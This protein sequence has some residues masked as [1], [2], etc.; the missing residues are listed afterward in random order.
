MAKPSAVQMMMP[1]PASAKAL[2]GTSAAGIQDQARICIS[3][4]KAAASRL[5]R[6]KAPL[7]PPLN[8]TLAPLG[9]EVAN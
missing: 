3:K 6:P 9:F 4:A 8:F 2:V 7:I 1:P 5:P